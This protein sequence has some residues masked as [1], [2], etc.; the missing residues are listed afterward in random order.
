M[1][2]KG[3]IDAVGNVLDGVDDCPIH[4][5]NKCLIFH[6]DFNLENDTIFLSKN[7][8]FFQL[9]F[10]AFF[11]ENFEGENR[12]KIVKN[13][14][15]FSFHNLL[16]QVKSFYT[17]KFNEFDKMISRFLKNDFFIFA[18][19]FSNLFSR[20]NFFEKNYCFLVQFIIYFWLDFLGGFRNEIC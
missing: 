13:F 11:Q 10:L 4:I 14:L 3:I 6:V 9:F 5:E 1:L 17:P 20:Q 2:L 18:S 12:Q 15:Q 7:H 16:Y 8:S 19:S